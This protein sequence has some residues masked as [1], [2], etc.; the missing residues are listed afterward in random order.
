MITWNYRVFHDDDGEYVIREVFYADDG[1]ILGCTAHA[2]EPIGRT[3]EELGQ[4][5]DEFK[6]ALTLPLLTLQDMP[7]PTSTVEERLMQRR[8]STAE[9]RALLG[10][11]DSESAPPTAEAPRTRKAS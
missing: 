9:A 4:S 8:V 6:A 3:L 11:D 1:T 5:I 2:V 7:A 10:L